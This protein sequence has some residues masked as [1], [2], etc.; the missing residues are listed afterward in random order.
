MTAGQ[1]FRLIKIYDYLPLD[2]TAGKCAGECKRAASGS[3]ITR[4]CM[5]PENLSPPSPRPMCKFRSRNKR[6]H[7]RRF[8]MSTIV[9]CDTL[10]HICFTLQTRCC[11][12][13]TFGGGGG[14]ST[15]V[16]QC[17]SIFSYIPMNR[18]V[19]KSEAPFVWLHKR[20]AS[21]CI[22][23]LD[24]QAENNCARAFYSLPFRQNESKALLIV[25][26]IQRL[27]IA[28]LR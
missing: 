10:W 8:V 27:N 4:R 18:E 9:N 20:G 15:L 14:F 2:E 25:L 24:G 23:Y 3:S 17:N 21:A 28:I 6:L 7:T 16:A 5:Q 26:L 13:D 12:R 22:L 11:F 19:Q 1:I